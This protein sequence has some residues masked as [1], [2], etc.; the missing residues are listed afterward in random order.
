MPAKLRG[1]VILM[2]MLVCFALLF[3][4]FFMAYEAGHI[5]CRDRCAICCLLSICQNLI[6]TICCVLIVLGVILAAFCALW[7]LGER[8]PALLVCPTLVVNKV[9]LSN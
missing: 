1:I 2:A 8:V 4:C 7:F 3:S 6:K 9:K 5:C